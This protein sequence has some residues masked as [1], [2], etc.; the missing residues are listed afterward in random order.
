M[1]NEH[2]RA[3]VYVLQFSACQ[4][5]AIEIKQA[6]CTAANQRKQVPSKEDRGQEPANC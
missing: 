1:K 3:C 5:L 2:V 4:Y 6:V